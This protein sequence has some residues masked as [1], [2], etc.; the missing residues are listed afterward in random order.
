MKTK[1]KTQAGGLGLFVAGKLQEPMEKSVNDDQIRVETIYSR[2]ENE[3][4][5]QSMSPSIPSAANGVQKKPAEKLQE[6]GTRDPRNSMPDD[7]ARICRPHG[8]GPVECKVRDTLGGKVD[9]AMQLALHAL[10]SFG[11]R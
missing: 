3:I 6:M 9:F 2:R 10:Q 4:K 8:R 7:P 11:A 5:A 1:K